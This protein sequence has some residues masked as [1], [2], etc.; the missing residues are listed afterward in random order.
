LARIF[1]N[2]AEG[3]VSRSRRGEVGVYHHVAGPYLDRYA[4]EWAW[5]EDYRR[6]GNEDQVKCTIAL[7][8]SYGRSELF[9]G[10]WQR[11]KVA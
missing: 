11:H 2:G 8:L 7:A 6:V 10:Y 3:Y 5:R 9:C 4:A 1:T